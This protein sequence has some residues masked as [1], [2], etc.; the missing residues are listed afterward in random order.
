MHI[1]HYSPKRAKSSLAHFLTG[2]IVSAAAGIAYLV[3]LVRFM[4]AEHYGGYVALIALIELFY[5][6]T[7]LGLSTIAQRY[8]AEFRVHASVARFHRFLSG[9]FLR[10]IGLSLLFSLFVVLGHRL[11]LPMLGLESEAAV[12]GMIVVLLVASASVFFL[13]EVLGALLFQGLSQG[14]GVMRSLLKLGGTAYAIQTTGGVTIEWVLLQECCIVTASLAIGHAVLHMKLRGMRASQTGSAGTRDDYAN[15]NMLPT[16]RKFYVVQLLGQTYAPSA[17]KLIVTRIL[18]LGGTAAFG[19]AQ[20]IADMLRNYLPAHLLAGWLRPIMVSRYLA[21][22]DLSDLT[23]ISNL[24]LKLNLLGIVPLAVFFLF[25]GDAFAHWITGGRYPQAGS[26]LVLLT[27]MVGLQTVHLMFSMITIT[28]EQASA[29]LAATVLAAASLPLTV[30]LIYRFGIEGAA[31]GL[32]ASESI[33]L[34]SAGLL[35]ARRGYVITWDLRGTLRILLAG[36]IAG[37][38]LWLSGYEEPVLTHMMLS[39]AVVALVF[40]VF[41]ALLKPLRERERAL[42]RGIMPGKLVVW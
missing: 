40:L 30:A 32:L 13:D 5:L 18:G 10:R 41:S 8:V 36:A 25:R 11:L 42:V 29:N 27:L 38:G 1:D 39:A 2:K 24:V 22:R 17:S 4:E 23:D 7:G 15:P 33:W 19:F 20:S 9:I 6:S 14:L 37:G 34:L 16:A 26:L 35:L 12:I 28:L 3:L 31:W 21:R